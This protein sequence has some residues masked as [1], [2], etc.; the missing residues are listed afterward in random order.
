[1]ARA[2][3]QLG[4]RD[5]AERAMVSTNTIARME[6]GDPLKE[7][8]VGAIQRALEAAGVIFVQENGD[9]PG[10][11]LR[12]GDTH[13]ALSKRIDGLQDHI[14][15]LPPPSTERSPKGALNQMKRAIAQDEIKKLKQ[16]KKATTN[17]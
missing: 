17:E 6:S 8:T 9:G 2:A 7:R 13:E 14:D 15:G 3:L 10:V 11:R 1:M 4:V 5:L 12:K 16:R